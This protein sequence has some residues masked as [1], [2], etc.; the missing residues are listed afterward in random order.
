MD[1]R[2]V[3]RL[4]SLQSEFQKINKLLDQLCNHQ[5]L[6]NSNLSVNF[7]VPVEDEF[8]SYGRKF[9]ESNLP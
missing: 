7:H 2:Y 4:L 5:L 9:F 1:E 8:L 6:E 3:L